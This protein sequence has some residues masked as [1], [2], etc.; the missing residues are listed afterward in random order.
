MER[1]FKIGDQV[2]LKTGSPLMTII[3]DRMGDDPERAYYF[4]GTYRCAW[5]TETNEYREIFTQEA[6]KLASRVGKNLTLTYV[7]RTEL[8][9]KYGS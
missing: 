7:G 4:D 8:T 1:K 6:L 2:V 9:T 3:N 5:F